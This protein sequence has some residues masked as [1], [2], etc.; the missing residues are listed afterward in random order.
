MCAL[1][2][3]QAGAFGQLMRGVLR[4]LIINTLFQFSSALGFMCIKEHKRVGTI[5]NT[6]TITIT[7]RKD[8]SPQ[9]ARDRAP[10]YTG[11]GQKNNTGLGFRR[12]TQIWGSEEQHRFGVVMMLTPTQSDAVG[13]VDA[14]SNVAADVCRCKRLRKSTEF[15]F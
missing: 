13:T 3:R 14:N 11:G 12:T 15:R 4:S 9:K 10:L 7:I 2:V 1:G 5:T 8:T 6:I